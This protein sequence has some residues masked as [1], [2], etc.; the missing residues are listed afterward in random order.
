MIRECVISLECGGSSSSVAF[1]DASL[2]SIFGERPSV[3]AFVA[4]REIKIYF[5]SGGNSW[6]M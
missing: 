5:E 4:V 3:V 1:Y 2:M 6:L